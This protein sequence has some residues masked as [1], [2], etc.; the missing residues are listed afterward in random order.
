MS[1]N[2]SFSLIDQPPLLPE[3]DPAM[4]QSSLGFVASYSQGTKKP[5]VQYFVH[6]PSNGIMSGGRFTKWSSRLM[7]RM[8]EWVN[9]TLYT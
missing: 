1:K 3:I 4:S 9:L 2:G 7:M 5:L 8:S 6:F